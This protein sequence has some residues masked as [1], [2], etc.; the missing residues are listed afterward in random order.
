M[1]LLGVGRMRREIGRFLGWGEIASQ[2]V[3]ESACQRRASCIPAQRQIQRRREGGA[4]TAVGNSRL[5]LYR[6]SRRTVDF[7]DVAHVSEAF[8]AG[9]LRLEV[10]LDAI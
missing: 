10:V 9:G 6:Y 5:D 4:P 1:I 2:Q 8:F 7:G 3:G